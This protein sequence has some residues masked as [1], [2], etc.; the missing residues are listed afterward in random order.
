MALKWAR[1]MLTSAVVLYGVWCVCQALEEMLEDDER[2]GFIVMDGSGTLYGTV[3][4]SHTKTNTDH[5][6][7]LCRD[8]WR[9]RGGQGGGRGRSWDRLGGKVGGKAAWLGKLRREEDP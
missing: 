1:V 2:F 4:V 3:Q 7:T 5:R 8:G 6:E 9:A